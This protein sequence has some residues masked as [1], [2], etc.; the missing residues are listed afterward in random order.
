M[1]SESDIAEIRRWLGS[2]EPPTDDDLYDKMD[3]Y[4]QSVPEVVKFF[5]D[6]RLAD[7][8]SGPASFS[9]PGYSENNTAVIEA[10]KDKINEVSILLP[11]VGG[12]TVNLHRVGR[13]RR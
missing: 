10:I 1:A 3:E 6:V 12:N 7:L 2:S 4:D 13:C 5:L 9:V 11:S 8:L